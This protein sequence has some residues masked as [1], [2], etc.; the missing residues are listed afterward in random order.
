MANE[1]EYPP[2]NAQLPRSQQAITGKQRGFIEDLMLQLRLT[3]GEKLDI[4]RDMEH[5]TLPNASKLI[6]SLKGRL[7]LR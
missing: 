5:M 6:D 3:D 4:R 2:M 7:G 1:Y